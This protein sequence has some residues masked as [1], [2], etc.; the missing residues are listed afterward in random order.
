[1]IGKVVSPIFW[2]KF[3]H[4][5]VFI[6]ESVAILYILYCGIFDIR[7]PWLVVAVVLVL[8]EIVIYVANGTRCPLTKLARRL[9]DKTGDDFIADIFLPRWFAPL[10]PPICGTLAVIGLLAMG[11]RLLTG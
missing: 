2:I 11:W 7:S 9:G 4:S 5:V 6:V 1:V 8:A 10:I 3:I